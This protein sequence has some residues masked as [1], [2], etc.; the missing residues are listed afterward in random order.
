MFESA[1]MKGIWHFGLDVLNKINTLFPLAFNAIIEST[2]NELPHAPGSHI[3]LHVMFEWN[4]Y[5]RG[6]VV[7]TST[8]GLRGHVNEYKLVSCLFI[9]AA[10]PMT[11]SIFTKTHLCFCIYERIYLWSIH[12]FSFFAVM[13]LWED[14]TG[15][16]SCESR[17]TFVWLG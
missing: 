7:W 8:Y 5:T 11:H 10:I 13:D 16:L 3:R 12:G 4:I 15:V 1:N 2:V 9:T 17:I 14:A 6:S